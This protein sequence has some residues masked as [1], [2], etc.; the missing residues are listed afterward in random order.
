MD[1]S[2]REETSSTSRSIPRD[3]EIANEL[4]HQALGRSLDE[5][6]PQTRKLLDMLSELVAGACAREKVERADYRFTRKQVRESTGWS[7]F[8][9]QTHMTKLVRLE[10]VLTHRGGRGQ[11]FVYELLVDPAAA[12][13]GQP[14]MPGLLDPAKLA[15]KAGNLTQSFEH[16]TQRFEHQK[17]QF[18]EYSSPHIAPIED[19]C[20]SPEIR[21]HQGNSGKNVE[22]DEKAPIRGV[23][24]VGIVSAEAAAVSRKKGAAS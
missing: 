7:D 2:P 21:S 16:L 14:V 13:P 11:S 10:H 8:Q 3:I 19:G 22:N 5:L 4:C 1:E 12:K 20:R 18:E 9:V 24:P 6:P 17:G 23:S 15:P